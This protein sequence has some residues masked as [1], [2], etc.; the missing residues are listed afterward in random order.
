MILK[1]PKCQTKYR[2]SNEAFSAGKRTVRC[3]RC[4]HVWDQEPT[5]TLDTESSSAIRNDAKKD[6]S[7]NRLSSAPSI[8]SNS[9]DLNKQN[10]RIIKK[11]H[12]SHSSKKP[13]K[14]ILAWLMIIVI[15]LIS[16]LVSYSQREILIEK[17]PFTEQLF[18]L[19]GVE[20]LAPSK[21]FKI[22]VRE[23][24]QSDTLF[25]IINIDVENI[26][27][28]PRVIP[29]LKVVIRDRFRNLVDSWDLPV[30][31]V[32]IMPAEKKTNIH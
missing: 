23:K 11:K 2:I 20:T 31:P 18:D 25:Q 30:A 13:R 32:K 24:G 4:S 22:N 14:V 10:Q 6:N 1:C 3:S 8:Q 21:F 26:S 9:Q 19:V 5:T 16:L 28:R 17:F 29:I 7:R 27:N 12:I 15:L